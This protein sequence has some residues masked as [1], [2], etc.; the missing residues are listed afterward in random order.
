MHQ[1]NL[2]QNF[3]LAKNVLQLAHVKKGGGTS[4]RFRN[5]QILYPHR[6][7]MKAKNTVAVYRQYVST[8]M[9]AFSLDI[10]LALMKKLDADT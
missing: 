3:P 6:R 9:Y 4:A 10:W 1:V 8:L 5:L 2:T 7:M